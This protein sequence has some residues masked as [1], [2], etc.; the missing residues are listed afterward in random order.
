VRDGSTWRRRG[1]SV[2]AGAVRSTRPLLRRSRPWGVDVAS[3]RTLEDPVEARRHPLGVVAI[4][5][6]VSAVVLAGGFILRLA[7]LPGLGSTR[8]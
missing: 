4:V 7:P 3:R 1:R 2:S 6:A 8:L 5:I